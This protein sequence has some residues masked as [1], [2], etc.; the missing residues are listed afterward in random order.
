MPPVH[1]NPAGDPP[2]G[3]P[4]TPCALFLQI[5]AMPLISSDLTR[6]SIA[7]RP[8]SSLNRSVKLV[9]RCFMPNSHRRIRRDATKQFCRVLSY[10]MN[11]NVWTTDMGFESALQSV[12]QMSVAFS[13]KRLATDRTKTATVLTISARL[14]YDTIRYDTRCYFNVRSKAD[15]SQLNLPHGTDN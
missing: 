1:P 6:P 10:G 3:V 12:A 7:F 14:C 8:S 15:I 5:L 9:P 11:W 13:L 4:H 2:L